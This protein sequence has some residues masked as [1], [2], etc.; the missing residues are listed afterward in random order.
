M[1]V[2]WTDDDELTDPTVHCGACAAVCCRLTVLVAPAD[3]VPR[4]L[5]VVDAQGLL[6]MARAAD[7][8]CVALDR[9]HMRCGIYAQR[10]DECRRF[11]MGAGYCRAL[12]KAHDERDPR[13]VPSVPITVE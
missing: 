8:W 9:Q 4:G 7:G 2:E 12:R 10:P 6:V 3:P 5:T 1:P 13:I 11:A